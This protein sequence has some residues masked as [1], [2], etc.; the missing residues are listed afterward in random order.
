MKIITFI[1]AILIFCT[2]M[3]NSEIS[4]VNE[5]SCALSALS[6]M[7]KD[8]NCAEFGFNC[9]YDFWLEFEERKSNPNCFELASTLTGISFDDVLMYAGILLDN[10]CKSAAEWYVTVCIMRDYGFGYSDAKSAM[11]TIYES[12]FA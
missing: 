3:Q 6:Q 10:Q 8:C 7:E 11:C 12:T 9:D 1:M 2:P 4:K 5:S